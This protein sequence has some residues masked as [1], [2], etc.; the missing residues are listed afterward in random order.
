MRQKR[1][2]RFKRTDPS[3]DLTTAIEWSLTEWGGWWTPAVDGTRFYVTADPDPDDPLTRR[4]QWDDPKT[5]DGVD[6][7][8]RMRENWFL[9][10]NTILDQWHKTMSGLRP[11]GMFAIGLFPAPPRVKGRGG[12][13]VYSEDGPLYDNMT[14]HGCQAGIMRHLIDIGEVDG[15]EQQRARDLIRLYGAKPREAPTPTG[16]RRYRSLHI[17]YGM[18][19][20]TGWTLR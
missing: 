12:V 11:W 3:L 10:G 9:Y 4:V 1:S 13:V 14:T 2:R 8:P 19:P 17:S 7:L 6:Y 5:Q 15:R 16:Y 18:G 20:W